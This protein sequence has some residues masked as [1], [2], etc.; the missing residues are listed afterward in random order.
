MNGLRLAFIVGALG[1]G[2]A[3][4]IGMLVGFTA[5]YRGG[6]VDE[7]LNMLTNVVLVIPTFAVLLV[8]AV[9]SA[10]AR[11]HDGGDLHRADVV[12]VGGARAARADVLAHVARVREPRRG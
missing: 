5:G 10:G 11:D 2:I 1:G 7:V 8:I 4:I 12:A 3:A 6:M 9:V